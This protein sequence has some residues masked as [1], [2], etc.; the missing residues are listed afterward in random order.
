MLNL[1]CYAVVLKKKKT[2]AKIN[3]FYFLG[4]MGKK[5]GYIGSHPK[6]KSTFFGV[7]KKTNYKLLKAFYFI[8]IPYVIKA[9]FIEFF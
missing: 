1:C 8:K 3:L 2:F 7:N 6:P 9:E 5:R 4:P